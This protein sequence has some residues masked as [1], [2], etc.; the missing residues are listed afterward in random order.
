VTLIFRSRL[1][2]LTA[3]LSALETEI[4]Q[5]VNEVESLFDLAL[6]VD[7]HSANSVNRSQPARIR[8]GELVVDP[9]RFTVDFR[10][11]GCFLGNTTRFRLFEYLARRPNRYFTYA[12][13]LA[14]VWNGA[15]RSDAAVRGA[16]FHL[17]RCFR[18]ARMS[19][20]ADAL[21][22]EGRTYGLILDAA[23]RWPMQRKTN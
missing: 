23:L 16:I 9:H 21:R 22:S 1:C 14:F 20:L 5:C 19:A 6:D 3:R 13:L 11:R 12:E 17:R 15:D 4:G 8:H 2:A 18:Q 7:P 10:R